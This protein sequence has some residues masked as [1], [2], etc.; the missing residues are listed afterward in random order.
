MATQQAVEWWHWQSE[1]GQARTALRAEMTEN[2]NRFFARRVA[3]APCLGRQVKEADAILTAL[4]E[5]RT[6]PKFTTFHQGAGALIS[7]AEW[8]SERASQVLTHFPREE[9]AVISRYYA[10]LPDFVVWIAKEG[11]AWRALSGLQKPLAGLTPSDLMHLRVQ[12][13]TAKSSLDLINLAGPNMLRRSS[14]LGLP[15]PT[16]EV[17]VVENF[18]TMNDERYQHFMRTRPRSEFLKS[19]VESSG[20]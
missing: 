9:V 6:P 3:L 7:D 13:E 19:R 17:K 14:L 2:N 4:E 8:Q 15:E 11:D 12:L 20:S 16:P 5:K 18:C 10:T 1:V